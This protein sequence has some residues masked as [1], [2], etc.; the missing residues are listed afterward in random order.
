MPAEL[1]T[2]LNPVISFV[3]ALQNTSTRANTL[4]RLQQSIASIFA[5]CES[6]NLPFEYIFVEWNPP[7]NM[8]NFHELIIFKPNMRAFMVSNWQH[9]MID[10]PHGQN[11]FEWRAK[12]VGIRRAAGKFVACINGDLIFTPELCERLK[13]LREDSFYRTDRYEIKALG[14]SPYMVKRANGNFLP[15]EPYIGISQTGVPYSEQ[16]LHFNS[17]GDF[18]CMSK[19]NWMLLRGYPE[20]DYDCC[21]DGS[22]V[23]LA[24]RAGLKQVVL[25]EHLYHLEHP[26]GDRIVH[27][28]KWS[29]AE[30]YGEMNPDDTWGLPYLT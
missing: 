4:Q 8:P 26:R 7:L 30:P 3:C 14:E 19:E 10:N 12:N 11:F 13:E 15:D 25:K 1:D 21:V 23:Y 20:T 9:K 24:H 2:N 6:V 16:M 5:S 28:P 27:V 18:M 29:D 22:M 17:S